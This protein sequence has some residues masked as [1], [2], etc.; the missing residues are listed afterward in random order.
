[1]L[2]LG[3]RRWELGLG[4]FE[5]LQGVEGL[6]IDDGV[7][8]LEDGLCLLDLLEGVGQLVEVS[9][10]L[11]LLDGVEGVDELGLVKDVARNPGKAGEEQD[12]G[13]DGDP[14]AL[15]DALPAALVLILRD[16]FEELVGIVI[17]VARGGIA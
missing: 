7:F 17:D 4:F 15:A 14:D 13:N 1:L 12:V 9:Q 10:V 6:L 16:F 2:R 3:S 5:S 8:R 11:A